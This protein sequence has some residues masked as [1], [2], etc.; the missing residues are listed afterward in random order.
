MIDAAHVVSTR[1]ISRVLRDLSRDRGLVLDEVGWMPDPLNEDVQ[2]YALVVT[3][4]GRIQRQ[5][6]LRDDLEQ[7]TKSDT[8]RGRILTTLKSFLDGFM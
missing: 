8:A 5:I 6:F 7:A 4:N 3:S 1:L 2:T